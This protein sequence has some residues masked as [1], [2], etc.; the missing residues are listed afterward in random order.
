MVSF[1]GY[2]GWQNKPRSIDM[3]NAR[4]Y[5]TILDEAAINS[6]KNAY[7]WSKYKEYL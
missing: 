2:M 5:M 4:E 3:L 1:D 7:D 6:G